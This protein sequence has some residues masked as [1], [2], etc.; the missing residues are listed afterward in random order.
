MSQ[1]G[2]SLGYVSW[3]QG[4]GMGQCSVLVTSALYK[5]SCGART[6]RNY[7]I[8]LPEMQERMSQR[9][10]KNGPPVLCW[11]ILWEQSLP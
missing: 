1:Q 5:K 11:Q 9:E 2:A 10:Q 4:K 8:Q 7:S 3:R 6:M